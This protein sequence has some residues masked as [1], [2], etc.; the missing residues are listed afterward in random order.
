MAKPVNDERKAAR[1]VLKLAAVKGAR[2]RELHTPTRI[3]SNES[4][5]DNDEFYRAVEN[6]ADALLP[7]R[8]FS[9]AL[10]ERGVSRKAAEEL[11][12]LYVDFSSAEVRAAFA[13]GVAFASGGAR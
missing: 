12:D 8:D 3:V 7:N 9:T 1:K 13:L 10:T 5:G 6:I 2:L 11:W 4:A